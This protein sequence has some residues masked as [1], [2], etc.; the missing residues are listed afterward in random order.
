MLR[1]WRRCGCRENSSEMGTVVSGWKRCGHKS[2][3]REPMLRST[4]PHLLQQFVGED[5]GAKTKA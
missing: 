5:V 3:T 2:L 1:C 4:Q